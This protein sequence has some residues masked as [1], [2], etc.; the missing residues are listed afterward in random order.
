MQ[1]KAL[2]L[3]LF[4]LASTLHAAPAVSK[5]VVLIPRAGGPVPPAHTEFYI[6][7]LS[8]G[9]SPHSVRETISFT[10]V[11]AATGGSADCT[12]STNTGKGV[13]TTAAYTKCSKPGFGFT[14]QAYAGGYLLTVVNRYKK[15]ENLLVASAW[16]ADRVRTRVNKANPNGNYKFLLEVSGSQYILSANWWSTYEFT[17]L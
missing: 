6:R 5:D 14:F 9:G 13:A 4:S 16:W 10:M 3:P 17:G 11:N 8:N 2:I 15:D 1:I 7:G 12:A